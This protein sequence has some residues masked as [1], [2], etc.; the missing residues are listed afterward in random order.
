MDRYDRFVEE[1][2]DFLL[3]RLDETGFA[4]LVA[5]EPK[6]MIAGYSNGSYYVAGNRW[7]PQTAW[8]TGCA[9]CSPIPSRV[10]VDPGTGAECVQWRA[11]DWKASRE[12][13]VP[14]EQRHGRT[15]QLETWGTYLEMN[16][17]AWPCLHVRSL[18]LPFADDPGYHD[19]WRPEYAVF[20]SGKLCHPYDDCQWPHQ[21]PPPSALP[22]GE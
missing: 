9:T 5:H 20:A 12:G 11:I 7:G 8:F 10:V 16:V 6:R 19:E 17:E 4:Q 22:N 3:I 21:L 2:L 1:L 14:H 13:A 18:A 15:H